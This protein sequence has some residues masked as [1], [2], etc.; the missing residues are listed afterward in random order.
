[1]MISDLDL[2][3]YSKEEEEEMDREFA[4]WVDSHSFTL[5]EEIIKYLETW[6]GTLE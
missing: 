1:M 6:D 3:L 2:K 5:N 4:A